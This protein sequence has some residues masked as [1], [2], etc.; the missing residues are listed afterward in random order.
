MHCCVY[1]KNPLKHV[2]LCEKKA[3]KTLQH[4]SISSTTHR[5][6][7]LT[8]PN[9]ESDL[10]SKSEQFRTILYDNRYSDSHKLEGLLLYLKVI[11]NR[12]TD[13]NIDTRIIASNIINPIWPSIQYY[14]ANIPT[15]PVNPEVNEMKE[16]CRQYILKVVSEQQR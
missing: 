1:D 3:H 11:Y 4:Q 12:L 8:N 6:K 9:M 13:R 7:Q 14:M 5:P 16:K 2:S 10:R 15:Q